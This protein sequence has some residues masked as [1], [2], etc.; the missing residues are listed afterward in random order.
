MI[1]DLRS[2]GHKKCMYNYNDLHKNALCLII[3]LI[4]IVYQTIMQKK[5]IK[6]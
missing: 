5:K 6:K 2:R 3:F 1:P 4:T